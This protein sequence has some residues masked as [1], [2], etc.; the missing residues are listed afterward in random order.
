VWFASKVFQ[1]RSRQ[2]RFAD[3]RL[4]REQHHLP[5]ANLSLRPAPQKQTRA[6]RLLSS[7]K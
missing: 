7:E 5:F 1:E 4:A 2:S 3:A 6:E